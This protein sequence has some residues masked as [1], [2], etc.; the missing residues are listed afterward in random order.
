MQ[1]NFADLRSHFSSFNLSWLSFLV[2][3]I[4]CPPLQV[5]SPWV[6]CS[7]CQCNH[8]LVVT[9]S[10]Q[11]LCALFFLTMSCPWHFF[12]TLPLANT[13]NHTLLLDN[14]FDLWLVTPYKEV[15][16]FISCSILCTLNLN[17]LWEKNDI[18]F[19]P[20]FFF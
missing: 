17:C 10:N 8:L 14:F 4:A 18:T 20:I 5:L 6:F 2:V 9:W 16:L 3:L 11:S 7:L 13:L 15:L 12:N 19:P 1:L